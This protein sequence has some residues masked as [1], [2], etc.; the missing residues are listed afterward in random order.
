MPKT[1]S[2][3]HDSLSTNALFGWVWAG[4]AVYCIAMLTRIAYRIRMGAIDEFGA[5]IHEFD[6]YFNY[7]ATEVCQVGPS[8]PTG[9]CGDMCGACL[10]ISWSIAK[11]LHRFSQTCFFVVAFQSICMSMERRSSSSGSITWCGIP[12]DDQWAQRFIQECSSQQFGSSDT[13]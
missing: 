1:K 7:R 10:H 11:I 5:V 4:A 13:F 6:P 8:V 3:K 9:R 2:S 12:W